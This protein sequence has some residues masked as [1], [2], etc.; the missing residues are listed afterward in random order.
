MSEIRVRAIAQIGKISR[1]L[2]KAQAH[3]GKFAFPA[4]GSKKLSSLLTLA[5][6]KLPRLGVPLCTRS[7]KSAV[8]D[9]A[10]KN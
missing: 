8:C 2:E 9:A 5:F 3:G 10:S 6:E 4:V 1:E 7:R